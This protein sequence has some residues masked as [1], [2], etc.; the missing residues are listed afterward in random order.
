MLSGELSRLTMESLLGYLMLSYFI[1]HCYSQCPSICT[2]L[3][4]NTT[5]RCIGVGATEVPNVP[6]T[7]RE[8]ITTMYE[9]YLSS[10]QLMLACSHFFVIMQ[11][12]NE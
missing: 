4:G 8:T 12:I 3:Q 1:G 9:S 5:L 11:R 7:L 2:C 6:A 10:Q